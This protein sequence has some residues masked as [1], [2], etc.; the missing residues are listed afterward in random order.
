MAETLTFIWWRRDVSIELHVDSVRK[1]DVLPDFICDAMTSQILQE[2]DE[3]KASLQILQ[4]NRQDSG[5]YTARVQN[6]F[7]YEL[8]TFNI[9]VL[10][11]RIFLLLSPYDLAVIHFP[12][13]R[14]QLTFRVKA[15]APDI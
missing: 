8:S 9:V 3:E 12:L 2:T 7:G 13:S 6:E 15:V 5:T 1:C 10:G 14:R 4:A 11:M